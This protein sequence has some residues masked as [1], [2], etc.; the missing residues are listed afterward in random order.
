MLLHVAVLALR[1]SELT[2][3]RARLGERDAVLAR[4]IVLADRDESID[5]SDR[6][7]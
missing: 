7:R 4:G 1:I 2:C 3:P 5:S 6:Y